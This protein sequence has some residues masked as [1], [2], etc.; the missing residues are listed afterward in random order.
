MTY[1]PHHSS[2]R[3]IAGLQGP[4]GHSDRV[5]GQLCSQTATT[6]GA[7]SPRRYCPGASPYSRLNAF[8]K[9]NSL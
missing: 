1:V 8:A 9:A 3:P 6:A 7:S 5:L 2:R 4:A